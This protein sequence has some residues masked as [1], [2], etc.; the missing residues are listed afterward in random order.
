MTGSTAR[1]SV[2]LNFP[3]TNRRHCC[4]QVSANYK[5][6]KSDFDA[7]VDQYGY[8]EIKS[9][10]AQASVDSPPHLVNISG[11]DHSVGSSED[12][13]TLA[14][15]T[16]HS[17]RSSPIHTPSSMEEDEISQEHQFQQHPVAHEHT[18][19]VA[20]HNS[21][22]GKKKRTVKVL[23]AMATMAMCAVLGCVVLP[24]SVFKALDPDGTGLQAANVIISSDAGSDARRRLDEAVS[25]H[26][27]SAMAKWSE[28]SVSKL[29]NE[30][31]RASRS[32]ESRPSSSQSRSSFV[33]SPIESSPNLWRVDATS[34]APWTVDRSITLFDFRTILAKQS[35]VPV[36][37]SSP[38]V[39]FR[40][41]SS[42]AREMSPK[43]V[44]NKRALLRKDA[45][46][47]LRGSRKSAT[48]AKSLEED[49]TFVSQTV[50]DTSDEQDTSLGILRDSAF[51]GGSSKFG[52]NFMF[53]PSA[54][55]SVTPGFLQLAGLSEDA[56]EKG[57]EAYNWA[58][59]SDM[60]HSAVSDL[61]KS[62]E[63]TKS[64][65]IVDFDD[66]DYVDDDMFEDAKEE[67][68]DK[69]LVP[70]YDFVKP[71]A[72]FPF[73]PRG[74]GSVPLIKNVFTGNDPY[75]SILVPASTLSTDLAFLESLGGEGGE[76]W[77]E[78]GCQVLSAK[79]VD[80]VHFVGDSYS[81]LH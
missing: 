6:L 54:F 28:M 15:N 40:F 12:E 19:A 58:K 37:K 18:P 14:S 16:A 22:I 55:A 68:M 72:S 61:H 69:A 70:K 80:G 20:P 43:T 26:E 59:G 51:G 31:I 74:G 77:V 21:R 64:D 49:Q 63:D 35:A 45:L 23:P 78:L 71:A 36:M 52:P 46:R 53:C 7:V 73:A 39:P 42:L 13:R 32:D 2:L 25:P 81:P 5:A 41:S 75:M 65:M 10:L 11:S 47:N 27:M 56:E 9:I 17:P 67:E 3:L 60:Q 50:S 48:E 62:K 76:P 4:S 57:G 66:D 24:P 8:K 29:M 79:L 44:A 1:S 33:I 38:V 30:P 34:N